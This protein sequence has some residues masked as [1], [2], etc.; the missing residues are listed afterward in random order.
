M[1]LVAPDLVIY[2]DISAEVAY[3]FS[4]FSIL[5]ICLIN[6]NIHLSLAYH[7]L[8]ISQFFPL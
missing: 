4:L 8:K 5:Y 1:G 6:T 7:L 2:L 3:M